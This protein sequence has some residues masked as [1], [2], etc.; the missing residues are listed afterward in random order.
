MPGEVCVV[1]F[2]NKTME[3]VTQF[4]S[5]GHGQGHNACIYILCDC[6][7][8]TDV[9]AVNS[10]FRKHWEL[11][12]SFTHMWQRDMFLEVVVGLMHC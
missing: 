11:G 5:E 2:V 10:D 4:I 9:L 8:A 1:L 7:K 12:K 6:Q 3:I